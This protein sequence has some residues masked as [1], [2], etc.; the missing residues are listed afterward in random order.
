[1]VFLIEVLKE[2]TSIDGRKVYS[3]D[4]TK[5]KTKSTISEA[6]TEFNIMKL[7]KDV[8]EKIRIHQCNH[9]LINKPCKII[10]EF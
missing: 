9:D 4:E 7:N 8:K 6:R 2:S 10:E 5:T 3:L 1:M